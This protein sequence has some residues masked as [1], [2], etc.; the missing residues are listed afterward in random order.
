MARLT[1]APSVARVEGGGDGRLA[2]R[3]DGHPPRRLVGGAPRAFPALVD[4]S[5]VPPQ[6]RLDEVDGDRLRAGVAQAVAHRRPP[7]VVRH[8][9]AFLDHRLDLDVEGLAGG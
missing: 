6:A 8:A 3:R 1:P 5:D 7:A 9:L 2:I 4:D